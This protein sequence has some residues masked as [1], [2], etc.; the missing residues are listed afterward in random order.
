L[1]YQSPSNYYLY[2]SLSREILRINKIIFDIIDDVDILTDIELHEK[3]NHDYNKFEL[4]V[5][6]KA[7]RDMQEK[8]LCCMHLPKQSSKI[9]RVLYE[10]CEYDVKEF[11][12]KNCNQILLSVTNKCNLRCKYCCYGNAYTQRGG[13][14]HNQN[15]MSL[16][17]AELAVMQFLNRSQF[18]H[19][20]SFYGG[21]PLLN[22]K[23]IRH[24]VSFSRDYAKKIGKNP[25]FLITTNGTLLS[26]EIV[27]F[28]VDNNIVVHISIDADKENHD[29]YRTFSGSECGSYDKVLS[30][31]DQFI[32]R[33]PVYERRGLLITLTHPLRIE[34]IDSFLHKY[35]SFFSV[36]MIESTI[37]NCAFQKN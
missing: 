4:D 28:I 16:K 7:V 32:K 26:D 36:I 24:V 29:H 23:L 19:V 3:W 6:I 10:D 37:S 20:I 13:R 22:F 1:K 27:D 9:N 15:E 12:S 8:G 30:N 33:Y 14:Q 21:E 25:F 5:S 31:I 2:D 17:T 34:S 35:A 11:L 18:M